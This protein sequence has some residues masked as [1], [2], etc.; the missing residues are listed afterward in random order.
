[1]G[2]CVYGPSDHT[3]FVITGDRKGAGTDANVKI[4]LFDDKGQISPEI[5]L[6]CY[7]KNN[8]EKGKTDSFQ[9]PRI[10][11]FGWINKIEFWR[12]NAGVEPDWFVD[13]FVVYDTRNDKYSYFPVLRWIKAD[14]HYT[15]QH[16]DTSLPQQDEYPEQRK[17]E[18]DEKREI[19]RYKQNFQGGPMQILELPDDEKFSNDYLWDIVRQKAE[20]LAVSKFRSVT[21]GNWDTLDDLRNI[22]GDPMPEPVGI[23]KYANDLCFGNQRVA[24]CNPNTIRL[25]TELPDNMAVTPEILRPF[26]EGWPLPQIIEAKR[27]FIVDYK[28]LQDL[29]TVNNNP[30][31]HPIALFFLTGEKELLPIAIQLKQK[32]GADNPVFFPN[33]PPFTWLMAKMWFNN[34]DAQYHQAICHLGATHLLAEGFAIATH[35]HM[36]PSHPM[37][38]LLA[39]HFYYLIAINWRGMEKLIGEGQWVDKVM[40]IGRVGMLELIKRGL[41]TWRMDVQGTLPK[42]LDN[43]GVLDPKVLPNYYFREDAMLLHKA[44]TTYVKKIVSHYYD[45]PEKI[46]EDTELQEWGEELARPKR[47][48]GLGLKGVPNNGKFETIEDLMCVFTCIIYMCSVAHAA[49]NFSQY[50]EYAF[51]PNYPAYISGTPPTDKT[52]LSEEDIVA[53][54]PDKQHTLDIMTVTKVLSSKG[55]NSLGH[56]ETQFQYDTAARKAEEDFKI[57]LKKISEM[58]REKNNS[59]SPRYMYLDPEQVP[60]SISI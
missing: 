45:I 33:D 10:A 48:G 24:G 41:N 28:I 8:F 38:K 22:Y 55:T 1:M 5:P 59:R 29:P 49:S 2:N 11:K 9:V 6:N 25:C 56:F 42:D 34:A 36:S 40:T 4:K 19:Y 58:I 47:E 43:R 23:M 60:N 17:K 51:P 37:F 30:L 39:P 35:R 20:L 15:I 31:C 21:T 46:A 27:L 16:L 52:P 18:L 32:M 44:I 26:L 50:D 54:L 57:E 14:Q 7:Y 12:D 53:A 13:R 3:V